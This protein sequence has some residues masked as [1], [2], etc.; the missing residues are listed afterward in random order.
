MK[1]AGGLG[2][3]WGTAWV[4]EQIGTLEKIAGNVLESESFYRRA[5]SIREVLAE[6]HP[7]DQNLQHYRRNVALVRLVPQIGFRG[8]E[9][10]PFPLITFDDQT[11]HM[12]FQIVLRRNRD[13][14]ASYL[15]TLTTPSRLAIPLPDTLSVDPL[16]PSER[17][18][19]LTLSRRFFDE[20]KG[21]Y[22][23]GIRKLDSRQEA[24]EDVYFFQISD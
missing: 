7:D 1:Q 21:T 11:T 22:R 18:L 19:R 23:I 14:S 24:V 2:E 6:R 10:P 16:H 15:P 12:E 17:T 20:G 4:L 3:T 8:P 5:D 13:L 9:T